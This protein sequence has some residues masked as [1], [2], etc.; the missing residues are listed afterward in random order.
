MPDKP[1]PFNPLDYDNLGESVANALLSRPVVPMTDLNR[2][3]GAGLYAIYYIGDFPPYASLSQQNLND[4]FQM[5]IYVGKA[6]REGK[7]TGQR[8][9]SDT[10]YTL[11]KRLREHA[12]SIQQAKNLDLADFR[13]RFLIVDDIWIPLGESL[14]IRDFQPLWNVIVSGF[15]NH[16]PGGGRI[17]GERPLWDMLHPG[18]SWAERHPKNQR[19]VEEI[20]GLVQLY[21]E[22]VSIEK[23]QRDFNIRVDE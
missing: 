9:D 5:P 18:R 13:C 8:A 2:F 7:R 14:M 1:V 6:E 12:R 17:S 23:L 10:T 21:S 11:Y 20:L 16:A 15:G 19:T 4:N 22:G 3:E